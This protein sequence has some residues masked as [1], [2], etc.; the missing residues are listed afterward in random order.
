VRE[1]LD[2]LEEL[3]K[4]DLGF[5]QLEVELEE[6]RSRLDGMRVDVERMRELLEREKRQLAETETLRGQTAREIEELGERQNRS[7]GRH[8]VAKNNRER[9]ATARELEVLKRERD[10]RT[11]KLAELDGVIP[12]VRES[13]ARHEGD[14]VKL[15]ELLQSEENEARARHEEVQRRRLAQE[16]RR[17]QAASKV[18]PDLLR[19]YNS[20]RERKGTAVAEITSSRICQACN[21]AI[22]PQLFARLHAGNE[23]FQCPSCQRILVLR[24]LN[25]AAGG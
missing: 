14:F 12:Q 16:G 7:S 3:A 22:P 1:Q 9:E 13:L 23:I 15:Q 2:A 6:M 19:K 10:E 8:N 18:R 11:A 17:Q 21:I 5:R 20:I 24:S 4:I 25:P